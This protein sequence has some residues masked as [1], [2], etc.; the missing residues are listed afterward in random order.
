MTAET[1]ENII[2]F[3]EGNIP[4][5]IIS[6]FCII[7]IFFILSGCSSVPIV[8]TGEYREYGFIIA[9]E[10]HMQNVKAL[11]QAGDP[12]TGLLVTELVKTA[13]KAMTNSL[14]SVTDNGQIPRFGDIHDYYSIAIYWWPNKLFRNGKPYI[15]KDGMRNPE[16]LEYDLPLLEKMSS[17]FRNLSLAFYYT[18]KP[19]Y[20]LRAAEILRHWF[21]NPETAMNPNMKYASSIPGICSGTGSGIIESISFPLKII[22]GILILKKSAVLK[23]SE[24]TAL[25]K[26]FSDFLD[27]LVT[28]GSGRE[29][30]MRTNNL[31]TYYW[32]EV[33]TI[34][35]FCGNQDA[36][37]K[38]V[39]KAAGLFQRQIKS[40]G[41]QPAELRRTK[42]FEYSV[43]NLEGWFYLASAA[44]KLGYDFWNFQ[45]KN[46]C[47][48]KSALEY[49]TVYL[50]KGEKWP[51]R[52]ITDP[53]VNLLYPLLYISGR[54]IDPDFGLLTDL[55]TESPGLSYK[56]YL[57][58]LL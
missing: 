7:L 16:Y 34:G 10:K 14:L 20:A 54:K 23:K 36:A 26:W 6:V 30:S 15:M 2:I 25:E 8:K 56:K 1:T 53:D 5:K 32:M 50:E 51:H 27:W 28:S 13:E 58:L 22:D 31:A 12:E 40:G 57:M 18:D 29:Q 21:I 3:N 47:S 42:S 52:N 11:Y 39:Q 38:A 33:I 24:I 49:L 45:P 19:D 4:V 37:E 41:S 48:L 17:D 46:G 44:E 35:L 55:L 43:F 9:D